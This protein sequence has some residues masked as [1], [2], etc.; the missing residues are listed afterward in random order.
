M[1]DNRQVRQAVI[2]VSGRP[3]LFPRLVTLFALC[4]LAM[5]PLLVQASDVV[6]RGLGPEPDSLHIHQEG[7]GELLKRTALAAWPRTAVAS[8]SG[9]DWYGF[10]DQ[11]VGFSRFSEGLGEQLERVSY[12]S[13]PSG[14]QDALFDAAEHWIRH[15]RVE[16]A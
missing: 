5:M 14:P 4:L 11:S 6:R 1:P 8:L 3:G 10:L 9:R 7:L 2:P 13:T 15:H 16:L 12:G